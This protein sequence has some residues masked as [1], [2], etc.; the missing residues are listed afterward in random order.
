MSRDVVFDES[1]PFYLRPSSNAS[2]A[3]LVDPLSFLL[4][5][6]AP[7]AP[8]SIPCSI[9]LSFVSFFESPLV[10]PDYTVNPLVTQFYNS[11]GARLSNAPSSSDELSSDVSSSSFIEDV[12][13]SPSVE[14][15]SPT[16]FSPEHLIIH[17]HRLHRP[18]LFIS[19]C[20]HNHCS[21]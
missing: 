2:P 1:R 16:D 9:L 21:F 20:F 17:S 10:V 18:W 11:H 6:D 13:S 14:P 12:P 3:S 4:F 15:S 7:P 5:P 8:L 19:F